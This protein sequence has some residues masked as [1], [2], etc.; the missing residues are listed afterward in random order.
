MP[1]IKRRDGHAVSPQPK[2]EQSIT[3]AQKKPSEQDSSQE[4]QECLSNGSTQSEA[5]QVTKQSVSDDL[6]AKREDE[7]AEKSLSVSSGEL[8]LESL[9]NDSSTL[10]TRSNAPRSGVSPAVN[11]RD[12]RAHDSTNM[13]DSKD[14]NTAK[15]ESSLVR[16]RNSQANSVGNDTV[17]TPAG[18]DHPQ[19][20]QNGVRSHEL[21]LDSAFS[22]SHVPSK[23]GVASASGKGFGTLDNMNTTASSQ[24]DNTPA[25]FSTD[26][27]QTQESNGDSNSSVSENDPSVSHEP[28]VE[29]RI[30]ETIVTNGT[31]TH[32]STINEISEANI[33]QDDVSVPSTAILPEAVEHDDD[34]YSSR[35]RTRSTSESTNRSTF[36]QDEAQTSDRDFVQPVTAA[37]STSSARVNDRTEAREEPS[38]VAFTTPRVIQRTAPQ[39]HRKQSSHNPSRGQYGSAASPYTNDLV[40]TASMSPTQPSTSRTATHHHSSTTQRPAASAARSPPRPKVCVFERLH[41]LVFLADSVLR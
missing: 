21:D 20:L 38:D 1:Q 37:D 11:D 3:E 15:S 34:E 9:V 32:L 23:N 17:S 10:Q 6:T 26:V 27:V 31:G 19:A 24:A 18:S 14:E 12:K 41:A 35:T 30:S 25:S 16:T 4:Q 2:A 29:S 28:E 5:S 33:S 36:S 13:Q 40:P 7:T 22:D 8:V 39:G